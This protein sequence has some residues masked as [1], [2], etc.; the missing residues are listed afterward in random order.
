MKRDPGSKPKRNLERSK[1][2]SALRRLARDQEI[3]ATRRR[4]RGQTNRQPCNEMPEFPLDWMLKARKRRVTRLVGA[5]LIFTGVSLVALSF[6]VVKNR[7]VPSEEK[8]VGACFVVVGAVTLAM[9]L[10]I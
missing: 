10:V 8:L 9:G 5:M 3:V 1:D 7:L 6:I 4:Q 2:P